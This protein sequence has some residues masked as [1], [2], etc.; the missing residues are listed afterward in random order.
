MQIT[1]NRYIHTATVAD[2][3]SWPDW[4]MTVM[5][6]DDHA[7]HIYATRH[8]GQMYVLFVSAIDIGWIIGLVQHDGDTVR[9]AV[10]RWHAVDQPGW[11]GELAHEVLSQLH[12]LLTSDLSLSLK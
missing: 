10:D 6:G 2:L 8:H 3:P 9:S 7:H 4:Q 1:E 12:L 11:W 5:S